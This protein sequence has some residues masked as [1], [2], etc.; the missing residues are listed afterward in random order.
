MKTFGFGADGKKRDWMGVHG[1]GEADG[2]EDDDD[3]VGKAWFIDL[4]RN[5]KTVV[6]EDTQWVSS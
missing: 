3:S 6:E 5:V 2:D 4:K 1:D